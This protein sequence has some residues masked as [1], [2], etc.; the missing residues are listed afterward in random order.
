MSHSIMEILSGMGV[1]IAIYLFL[2]KGDETVAVIRQLGTTS[3]SM[4]KTLQGR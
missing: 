4:V 1:L 2:S 3:T